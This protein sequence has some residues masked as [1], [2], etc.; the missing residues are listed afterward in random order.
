MF[1]EGGPGVALLLL[2][3]SAAAA[4]FLTVANGKIV[5]T[6]H[7]TLPCVVGLAAAL[8]LGILTPVLSVLV[9]ALE[10]LELFISDGSGWLAQLLPIVNVVALALLGPGAYS[11]DAWLFGR[12]VLI[13]P[14]ENR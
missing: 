2:R 14:P 11:I 3:V 5:A 8:C 6:A 13:S 4:F 1:P 9:A 7:W 10:L 12:R